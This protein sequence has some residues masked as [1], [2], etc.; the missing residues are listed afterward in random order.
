MNRLLRVS[1]YACGLFV[2]SLAASGLVGAACRWLGLG[3]ALTTAFS[4]LASL[5]TAGYLLAAGA[6]AEEALA[7]AEWRREVGS[8][9]GGEEGS[10]A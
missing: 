4:V 1:T 9:R 5:G 2:L 8:E 10:D 6:E 7:D 3:D